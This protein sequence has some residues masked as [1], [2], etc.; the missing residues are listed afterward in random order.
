ML[1]VTGKGGFK[2]EDEGLQDVGD[3]RQLTLYTQGKRSYAG[4]QRAPKT[5]DI[6]SSMASAIGCKRGQVG[7]EL[8]MFHPSSNDT[9]NINIGYRSDG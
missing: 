9:L 5:C 6:V 8:M 7:N 4:C 1:D 2:K 3:W